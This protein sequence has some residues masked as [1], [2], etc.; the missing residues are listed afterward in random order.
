MWSC[1]GSNNIYRDICSVDKLGIFL[2]RI[3]HSD[4]MTPETQNLI[5]IL[6]KTILKLPRI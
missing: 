1:S 2:Y 6:Y 3:A 4:Y 5:I